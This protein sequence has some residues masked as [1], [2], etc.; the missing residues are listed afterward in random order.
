MNKISQAKFPAPTKPPVKK[1]SPGGDVK[2]SKNTGQPTTNTTKAKA[3]PDSPVKASVK[4]LQNA[5]FKYKEA[6][7]SLDI[8]SKAN[9][10]RQT[11]NQDRLKE[12]KLKSNQS[13][14]PVGHKEYLTDTFQRNI[15]LTYVGR[16]TNEEL[17]NF[18]SNKEMLGGTNPLGNFLIKN[19]L[20]TLAVSYSDRDVSD[21]DRKGQSVAPY[22]FRSL[23]ETIGHI[24][25]PKAERP[26]NFQ[27]KA[28]QN[29][30]N[31]II[32][33]YNPETNKKAKAALDELNALNKEYE[34]KRRDLIAKKEEGN[35]YVLPEEF[36]KKQKAIYQKYGINDQRLKNLQIQLANIKTKLDKEYEAKNPGLGEEK[37]DGI[38]QQRTL[39]ALQ[40]IS[41]ITTALI[42]FS[43]DMG[44]QVPDLSNELTK[45]NQGLGVFK[46]V[47]ENRDPPQQD[48]KLK[49]QVI[50]I[51]TET[52]YKQ[53]DFISNEFKQI[54]EAP[55]VRSFVTQEHSFMAFNKT[56]MKN[57]V[58]EAKET[59]KMYEFTAPGRYANAYKTTFQDGTAGIKVNFK[60]K[61]LVFSYESL[62]TTSN[63]ANT[64]KSTFGKNPT[65]EELSE[66]LNTI[67]QTIDSMARN[68][69]NQ[70]HYD[71]YYRAPQAP[72]EKPRTPW[73]ALSGGWNELTG[74]PKN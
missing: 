39:N 40:A 14:A 66:L 70:K 71:Q 46:R 53:A 68:R 24:G 73:Q 50:K 58:D 63:L 3:K 29:Q 69:A 30:I 9:P 65:R 7:E 20:K 21:K 34:I 19:Y 45:Y 52:V 32:E 5:I 11:S 67:E 60:N 12:D 2:N 13:Y 31:K 44:Q 17:K 57:K 48:N 18:D 74:K 47:V 55:E 72:Q 10:G 27:E 4:G 56:D 41:G 49:E 15:P 28:L 1:A 51:L 33:Q 64:F 42:N 8:G 35:L 43:K 36:A 62:W 25:T 59:D 22:D 16:K 37:I 54:I 6:L 38:F 61:E 23:V 26:Q